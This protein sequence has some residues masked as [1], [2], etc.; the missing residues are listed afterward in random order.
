MKPL[1]RLSFSLLLMVMFTAAVTESK[2]QIY[3]PDGVR[4]PGDWNSWT[5]NTGMG[6]D[7]DL[8][9]ITTGT[10]R[11]QTAFHYTGSTEIQNFKFVSTGFGEPW[12]NQW[13]ENTNVNIDAIAFFTY[14]VT[15]LNENSI[16]VVHDKWYTVVFEDNGYQNTR[17]IFME[18]S[19]QPVSISSVSQVPVVAG[20]DDAVEVAAQLSATPSAEELFY[21]RYTTDGWQTSTIL[22]MDVSGNSATAEIPNQLSGTEVEY[23]ILSSTI[24]NP[25]NDFDLITIR[26]NNNNGNNFTYMVDQVAGCSNQVLTYDPAFPFENSSVTITLNTALGNKALRNYTGDVYVH[27]GVITNLSNGPSDWRYVKTGWGQNTPETK[28]GKV[29]GVNNRYTLSISN[30]RDYY[31]VDASEDILQL[32]MVFRSDGIIPPQPE[33]LVHKNSDGS[34]FF[35]EVFEQA[36]NV[37]ILAPSNSSLIGPDLLALVCVEAIENNSL[38]I[39]LNDY[40][41]EEDNV[42]SLALL[43]DFDTLAPG[44]HW[45]KAV[46]SDI[47]EQVKD[48]VAVYLPGLLSEAPLPAGVI[49][50]INYIDDETVT[51]VLHDPP[52]LKDHVFVI[53][54]FNNWNISNEALMKRTPDGAFFWKTITGLTPGHEYAFQYFIDTELR[55]ADPYTHKVLDPWNDHWIPEYNYPDLK[56][57]P[58]G[59][60]TGIVSVLQTAQ[61]EYQWEAT[62]FTLP[63]VRDLV[64][65]ELHIRDFVE[66]DAIK[67][68]MEKLDYLQDLGVNAIELMPINEFEGNDSWGYNPSFYF[69]ADKAYGTINDYKAFIDECH[70]RGMAVILDIVLNHSFNLSPLVQ[71]YFDPDAGDW[72]KPSPDNPWYLV[73]CPHEPW[74]WGNTFDQD[75]PYTKE[76]F[77]R[78]TEYWLTEFNIDGFRFDFTKGFTNVQSGNQGNDYDAARVANLKRIADEVWDAKPG[79]Y[80]ILEHL[81]DNSEEVVLANYGMLIWGNMNHQYN[82]ATMGWPSDLSWGLHTVRGYTFHNLISYMESHD[83]ERLMFK[84]LLYGNSTNP[85]HD[86]KELETALARNELAAAFYLLSP[87]PKMIWQFGELGYDFP[88]NHCPDGSIDPDCRTSRKPIPWH[89]TLDYFNVAERRKLYDIYSL[90]TGLKTNH[91]VFRTGN[92][93]HDLSGS[94]KRLWLNDEESDMKVLLLGKFDVLAGD[95]VPSF[96]HPGTWYEFFTGQTLEVTDPNQPINLQPGEYRLY[97]NEKMFPV[98]LP[99]HSKTF[100]ESAD[101]CLAASQHITV[102]GHGAG[103]VFES[104]SNVELIAGISVKLR[105]DVVIESGASVRIWID[106]TGNFCAPEATMLTVKAEDFYDRN[107]PVATYCDQSF[108]KT[109]PNPT[110]GFLALEFTDPALAPDAIITVYNIMGE[111]LLFTRS[112]GEKRINIDLDKMPAGIYLIRVIGGERSGFEKII[113][114]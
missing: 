4:M 95:I 91:T 3:P 64:I 21:L 19:G 10:L 38:A 113:K 104:G 54:D 36:L 33:Y 39:Y 31:G 109:F 53:G 8:Q 87:G 73:D 108:F 14:G 114:Q 42:Q 57:Y 102:A 11:W 69:A 6:G 51:L 112:P 100:S 49:N 60:T 1:Y 52:A 7:F 30:I 66:T 35:V 15:D 2:A 81:T 34:D 20:A 18:T 67:S 99:L 110:T 101:T 62:G 44:V 84:N 59:K 22:L 68:V 70:R 77:R 40:L 89:E 88:I 96:Q 25:A 105:P 28:L 74:C 111:Q 93:G 98:N 43:L 48:S 17:A 103:V 46:A 12:H 76:F 23:Y 5:N 63:D 47:S 78:I 71:M 32:A 45:I 92:I 65:Y 27:T 83:E 107:A 75:S 90:L 56:P 50:G 106:E 41:I 58:Q 85:A 29:S 37:K 24:L 13:A 97:S 82:E 9:R 16:S 72:G 79:A 55:L 61:P 94:N 26:F 86:V 80:V